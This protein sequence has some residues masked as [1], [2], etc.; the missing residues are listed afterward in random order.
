MICDYPL[1]PSCYELLHKVESSKHMTSY[2]AR[3]LIN[4][5]TVKLTKIHSDDSDLDLSLLHK[6][7]VIWSTTAHARSIKYYGSFT[8]GCEIWILSQYY[9]EGSLK[10]IMRYEF[11]KGIKNEEIIATILKQILSFLVYFHEMDRVHGNI[12]PSSIYLSSSG[13]IGIDHLFLDNNVKNIYSANK[14][15]IWNLGLTAIE[16]ATGYEPTD[17]STKP[18]R[19]DQFS[20]NFQNF[21]KLCL[22][23][24]CSAS[25]LLRHNFIKK[26][27]KC[28]EFLSVE[29]LRSLPPLYQ[30]FM[31]L[32][33][34]IDDSPKITFRLISNIVFTEDGVPF[35]KK[36]NETKN[37]LMENQA[38][39]ERINSSPGL[40]VGKL[41]CLVRKR[42][43]S[44]NQEEICSG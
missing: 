6:Q 33:Q 20:L 36:K 30:R 43:L 8:H 14:S 27:G 32:N 7:L 22:N 9:D 21:V 16:M 34:N 37:I 24:C 42:T 10:D 2:V 13:A 1:D 12:R 11:S 15:D 25:E 5:K 17:A 38:R 29:L 3:C 28:E 40:K 4:N 41:H 44:N 18:L 26:N 23:D 31:I 19:N 35:G 39:I